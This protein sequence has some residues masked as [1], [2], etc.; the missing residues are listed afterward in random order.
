MGEYFLTVNMLDGEKWW[1]GTSTDGIKMP[2]DNTTSAVRVLTK[3]GNQV[4]PLYLSNYGR[5]I[6]SEEPFEIS[7]NGGEI[8]VKGEREILLTKHGNSL[9]EGYLGAMNAYF[10]PCGNYPEK[11]FF[12]VPQYNTWMQL[13]YEQTQ[14]GVMEYAK[15]LIEN[16]YKPGIIMID[17]G[18]QRNYGDWAFNKERFPQPKKMVDELHKMGFKVMLWLVPYVNPD[19][20]DFVMH[21]YKFRNPNL[22]CEYF[23][24]TKSGLPA[25]VRWWNGYSLILDMTK[26]CDRRYLSKQLDVLMQDYGIDGFKF[27]GGNI[28]SYAQKAYG[29]LEINADKTACERNVAWNEFG[30]K[31]AYHEYKD[32]F[33]GGGKRTIQRTIDRNHS[34]DNEGINTL[35]PNAIMQG[36]LGHPFICPDMIGGGEWTIKES[37]QKVDQELFVRMSQ[38]SALF[39]MMQFSWAPWQAVDKEHAKLIKDAHDLHLQYGE[40]ILKLVDDA[41][42]TGEPIL[43]SLE[44]N[45]PHCGYENINDTFM[46]GEQILV[47][48]IVVKGQTQRKVVLPKG[49]WKGFDG[50]IYHGNQTISLAVT[51]STLPFFHKL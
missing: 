10:K 42:K 18:W 27:D 22:D 44:Y 3:C 17:E 50:K 9:R 12:R 19:G 2:F 4:M 41:V 36:I 1:G 32:T 13:V 38:C 40:T 35:V 34:W 7:F 30:A 45:Y 46:L 15:G 8:S 51:L 39:P 25:I 16:G 6:W 5:V 31:Y 14:E 23:L 24:R 43:R 47:A 26:E 29:D 37:Q 33:K 21:A 48:P 20:K 11:E 49:E 28:S